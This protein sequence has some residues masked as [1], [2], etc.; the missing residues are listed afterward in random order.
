LKPFLDDGFAQKLFVNEGIEG[1][2][3]GDAFGL[4][5][6]SEGVINNIVLGIMNEVCF[7]LV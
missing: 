4:E 6:R 7:C 1:T 3:D 5:S 2:V